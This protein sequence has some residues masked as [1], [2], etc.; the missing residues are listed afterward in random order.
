MLGRGVGGGELEV[1]AGDQSGLG[2]D[3][4]AGEGGVGCLLG[5]RGRV[6]SEEQKEGHEND[7]ASE[8]LEEVG[9]C[10]R[11]IGWGPLAADWRL[12]TDEDERVVR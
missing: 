10:A 6:S 3:Y 2:I 1:G 12:D 4:S 5:M 8:G 9:Q 11:Q 7:A